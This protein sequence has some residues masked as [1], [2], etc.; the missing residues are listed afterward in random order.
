MAEDS[1]GFSRRLRELRKQQCLSP[2]E[3]GQ[4]AGRHSPHIGRF[5]RGTPRPSRDTLN[6]VPGALR[7]YRARPHLTEMPTRPPGRE[8]RIVSGTNLV[9]AALQWIGTRNRL[10]ETIRPPSD[11]QLVSGKVLL[12]ELADV[13][14]PSA[15]KRLEL[16][17]RLPVRASLTRHLS[18]ARAAETRGRRLGSDFWHSNKE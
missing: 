10:L 15:T 13:L 1:E 9:M 6:S 11:V 2:T 7:G 4:L 16:T 3:L 8:L 12:E 18:R 14:K 17:G 5:E